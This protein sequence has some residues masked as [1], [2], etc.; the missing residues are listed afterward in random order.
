VKKFFNKSPIAVFISLVALLAAAF[1]LPCLPAQADEAPQCWAVI[2]SVSDYQYINDLPFSNTGAE[3]FYH[4]LSPAWGDDHIRQLEDLQ[5]SKAGILAAISWMVSHAGYDDTVLF[6][7]SGHGSD[8]GYFCPWDA[9]DPIETTC[10][11]IEDLTK[12]LRTVNADKIVIILDCCFSGDFKDSL[13]NDKRVILMATDP[14]QVGWQTYALADPVFT[15]YIMQAFQNFDIADTNQDSELSAQ[16]IFHYAEPLVNDYELHNYYESIQRPTISDT[17]ITEIPLLVRFVF[18]GDSRLPSG[19]C[20]LT[21]DGV[22]YFMTPMPLF[23]MPSSSHVITVPLVVAA[24]SDTRYVFVDWNDDDTSSTKTVLKGIFGVNYNKEYL[25]SIT[26]DYADPVGE[27]W[28]LESSTA[29]FSVVPIIETADTRHIFTGW[30][31]DYTS[32]ATAGSLT[33]NKP[34]TLIANWRDEYLLAVD[35]V[36]GTVTGAGWYD[37]NASAAIGITP[38]VETSDTRRYFTG[39]SGDA[40]GTTPSVSL[41]MD[42]PKRVAAD[43]RSEYLVRIASDYGSPTGGGWYE[44]GV[45]ATINVAPQE[46]FIIRHF[47]KGWSGDINANQ[48]NYR[49]LVNAPL[50]ITALWETDYVQLYILVGVVVV[51][52]GVTVIIV[53]VVRRRKLPYY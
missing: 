21:I 5:A 31:G 34:K 47:F 32:T 17:Y 1:V 50:V 13:K 49:M 30:S 20:I 10:I 38:Y 22:E 45:Q 53:R 15:Y 48:T 4:Q 12:A 43:W 33:M 2:A 16:E 3:E 19:T 24:S 51:L 40:A 37:E 44:E 8:D 52:G 36:Y 39:W 7:F 46:G 18:S 35:S 6:Y 14:S 29:A 27:G 42:T 28:Y 23:W 41:Y 11:S 25:L 26:S 9:N